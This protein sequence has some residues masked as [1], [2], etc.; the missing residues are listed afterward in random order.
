MRQVAFKYN[1]ISDLQREIFYLKKEAQTEK[2]KEDI[3]KKESW[4]RKNQDEINTIKTELQKFKIFAAVFE[5]LPQFIL[6]LSITVKKYYYGNEVIALN[7]FEDPTIWLIWLQI[8]SSILSV[9]LTL[10]SLMIQLPILVHKTERPPLRSLSCDYLKV[11]LMIVISSTPQLFTLVGMASLANFE[12]WLFYIFFGI[13]YGGLLCVGGISIKYWMKNQ[14]PIIE[15]YPS[16][17]TV[18]DLGLITSV[19][20]P[21]VIGV[22]NS[23]FLIITS[24]TATSIHSLALGSLCIVGSYQPEW[25]FNSNA[26]DIGAQ[27]VSLNVMES[28]GEED[29][30]ATIFWNLRWFTFILVPTLL[31]VS[32]TIAFVSSKVVVAM[33]DLY[34]AVLSI[35]TSSDIQLFQT[36]PKMK[37][38]LNELL[39]GDEANNTLFQHCIQAND[40]LSV[41]LIEN[42]SDEEVNL[43]LTNNDDKTALM[44]ACE[45]ARPKT[46]E[47]ILQKASEGIKIGINH[48]SKSDQHSALHYAALSDGTNEAKKKII[49]LFWR[50]AKKLQINLLIKNKRGKTPIYILERLQEGK[51]WLEEL[52]NPKEDW[53]LLHTLKKAIED[54]DFDLVLSTKNN[55]I[56]DLKFALFYAVEANEEVAIALIHMSQRLPLP[57]TETDENNRTLLILAC[58]LEKPKIANAILC[59]AKAQDIAIN[60]VDKFDQNMTSFIWACRNGWT[61]IVAKILEMEQEQEE[62]MILFNAK[63]DML[64]TG[65]IWACQNKHSGVIDLIIS[66]AELL[67]IDLQSKDSTGKSGFIWACENGLKANVTTMFN[68]T[69]EVKI[70]LNA[71]DNHEMTGFIHACKNLQSEVIDLIKAHQDSLQIDLDCIDAAGKTG[72]DYFPEHFQKFH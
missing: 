60:A 43:S 28:Q 1:T 22:F 14:Y 64:R 44:L 42:C 63:D 33:N 5:S 9:Y 24:V 55:F 7:P 71:K 58:R 66:K 57:L 17:S 35:E 4:I 23:N 2:K 32:N 47:S 15:K 20:C 46:V 21:C 29:Q 59:Q 52:G 3:V 31:L 39:P 13:V 16:I 48:R 12:D 67:Q 56:M 38:K 51:A 45:K 54:K 40:D 25:M 61:D 37:K 19:I 27:A 10:T 26:S 65:F 41:Q 68:M 36:E 49:S 11:N 18:I 72:F 34:K 69:Q 70:D 50:D 62:D 30:Y 6:Q 8:S 53:N